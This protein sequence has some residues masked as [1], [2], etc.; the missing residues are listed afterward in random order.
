VRSLSGASERRESLT[1][2]GLRLLAVLLAWVTTACATIGPA[3]PSGGDA[4]SE[5]IHLDMSGLNE[6]GLY[7]PPNGLQA[8][9]YEFCIP[10]NQG[11]VDD[12]R[13]IDPT[14]Q[15]YPSSRGRIGCTVE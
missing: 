15:V 10:A 3:H 5:K 1:G 12:V 9:S 14:I 7:G 8:L 4:V 13:A 6:D 2:T 11:L